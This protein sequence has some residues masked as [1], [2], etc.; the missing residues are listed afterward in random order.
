M[1]TIVFAVVVFSLVILALSFMLI[2]AKS[3]WCLKAT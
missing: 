1:I 3:D 2:A